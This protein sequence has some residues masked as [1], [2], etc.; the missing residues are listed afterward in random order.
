MHEVGADEIV[1]MAEKPPLDRFLLGIPAG[2]SR[3]IHRTLRKI[4]CEIMEGVLK[5]DFAER[6]A[7]LVKH[8]KGDRNDAQYAVEA[9][10]ETA[11][12]NGA[13]KRP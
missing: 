1:E 11:R 3:K 4:A 10:R 7:E 2:D 5:G 6:V 9:V 13:S 12:Q 8:G